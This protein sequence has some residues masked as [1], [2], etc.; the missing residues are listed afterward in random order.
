MT[1]KVVRQFQG[2]R[3]ESRTIATA[4]QPWIAKRIAKRAPATPHHISTMQQ[5][6]CRPLLPALFASIES[7][8]SDVVFGEAAWSRRRKPKIRCRL[9]RVEFNLRGL[10]FG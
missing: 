9:A 6:D 10:A 1:L 7:S 2:H 3:I 5:K 4:R 8:I